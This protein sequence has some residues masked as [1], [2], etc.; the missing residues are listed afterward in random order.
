M[1]N[2]LQMV[3]A[4]FIGDDDVNYGI[5]GEEIFD[6]PDES[7]TITENHL[8]VL[9]EFNLIAVDRGV[10]AIPSGIQGVTGIFMAKLDVALNENDLAV[11]AMFAEPVIAGNHV[12]LLHCQRFIDLLPKV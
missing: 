3:L 1:S 7:G 12:E 8:V 11:Y 5:F 10:I 2:S 4:D 9:G 6:L